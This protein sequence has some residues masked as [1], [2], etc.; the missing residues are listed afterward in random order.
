LSLE[1][2]E[3]IDNRNNIF[4]VMEEK[5][6]SLLFVGDLMF[7]R[8]IRQVAEK[9]GNEYIFSEVKD[10]LSKEDLV[11][12]NL[13]G[14][15]TEFPSK[16]VNTVPGQGG[17][18][19]FTLDKSLASTLKNNNIKLVNLGN[20]HIGNFGGEGIRQTKNFLDEAGVSYF[21]YT[22]DDSENNYTILNL[23]GARV[24]FVNYN[25]FVSGSSENAKKDI[26]EI[27]DKVDFLVLYTHWDAEYKAEPKESTKKLAREFIDSGVDLLIGTHP[28]V[29]QS[30]EEYKNKMIYYSLGDFVFDQYFS[31]E[32]KRGLGVRVKLFEKGQRVEFEEINF[33][34]RT[35]GQTVRDDEK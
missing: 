32:T 35:N 28:H 24:G 9:K 2:S 23:G 30:K 19:V 17:H 1:K 5:E 3:K 16:S 10:I 14:P 31:P 4:P 11:I 7:D 22:G 34:L 33:S 6:I 21:G 29:I 27:R 20:N 12:A 25:Q 15:I 8:Y 13:E 18:L 26:L